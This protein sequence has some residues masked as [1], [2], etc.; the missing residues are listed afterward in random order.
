M[1]RLQLA[2]SKEL[3]GLAR[4][5]KR[6]GG[7]LR[8][9]LTAELRKPTKAMHDAVRQDILTADLSGRR[10]VRTKPGRV[11]RF[12]RTGVGNTEP[13]RRPTAA[14]LSWK[15][16]TSAGNPRAV[17]EFNW[18]RMNPRIRPLFRYW[19]GQRTRLRHPVMG[20]RKV[21]VGQRIP[22]VWQQTR[23]LAPEAQKAVA[24]ACDQ[25]AAII[26]GRK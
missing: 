22:D 3:G 25:T 6:A 7:G 15:V 12:P 4:D 2:G 23:K 9:T 26:G 20:N 5:L 18:S 11:R 14:A 13:L 17:V 19:V 10:Y 21:W 24:R 1:F 16:S 8:P